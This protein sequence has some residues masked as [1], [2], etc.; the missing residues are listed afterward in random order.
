MRAAT[1]VVFGM[2]WMILVLLIGF[3]VITNVVTHAN[4]SGQLTGDAGTAWE[5]FITFVWVAMGLLAFTPLIL[6]AVV[7]GGLLGGFGGEGTAQF[8]RLKGFGFRD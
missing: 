5:T 2:I 6:V 7:F 4:D 1:G 3:L 8:I